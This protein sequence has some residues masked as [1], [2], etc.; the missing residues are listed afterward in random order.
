MR[1]L[2]QICTFYQKGVCAYGTRCRY[3]HIKVSRLQSS[4]LSS[5]A[6]VSSAK[7]HT[8][9][10][11]ALG[12]SVSSGV[13]VEHSAPSLQVQPPSRSAWGEN[14]GHF[15]TLQGDD[16]LVDLRDIDPAEQPI[17]SFAAAGEC[18]HGVSCPRIH[19]DLCPTCR[20]HCL[21][22]FRPEEREEHLST[23][24]KRQKHLEA[25]THSQEIECS[26]CLE[27]IL[28]KPTAAERKFGILSECDHPFCVSCI[29]NWRSTSRAAGM[30]ANSAL[31]SC[32][33]CR[34]LSYFVIPSV[35]WYS[36][37]EDKEEI[38]E[39]YKSKL[40][41]SRAFSLLYCFLLFLTLIRNYL[42]DL[43]TASTLTSVMGP[44]RLGRVVFTRYTHFLVFN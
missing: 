13:D 43:L 5:S 33:I 7:E 3:D 2:L 29:R 17:C 10:A 18:P 34:K 20:K 4:A 35:I 32:P 15:D 42:S 1:T 26:V 21:H 16:D 14:S 28:S 44:A 36:S 38:V 19:G 23:C 24:E 25:L 12:S 40:R 41:Y 8:S 37:K 30:D 11:S 22:P 6:D 39:S 9:G 27:K 31:R